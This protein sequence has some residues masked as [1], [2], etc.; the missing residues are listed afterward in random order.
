MKVTYTRPVMDVAGS[1][2]CCGMDLAYHRLEDLVPLSLAPNAITLGGCVQFLLCSLAFFTLLPYGHALI[3][4]LLCASVAV[5]IACDGVDGVHARRIGCACAL[6]DM[7]DNGSDTVFVVFASTL[8]VKVLG[9]SLSSTLGVIAGTVGPWSAVTSTWATLH[10]GEDQGT[11]HHLV[12]I[13][14][15][16]VIG[17]DSLLQAEIACLCIFGVSATNQYI[18]SLIVA[19]IPLGPA[20]LVAL[21]IVVCCP[22]TL[23]SYLVFE[24]SGWQIIMDIRRVKNLCR[25]SYISEL[26]ALSAQLVWRY[27]SLLNEVLD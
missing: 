27:L 11:I 21:V 12:W 8:L 23:E 16:C 19:G 14:L 17:E 24:L 6:G 5:Y 2:L 4:G 25:S 22:R 15:I 13:F 1:W 9:V 20:I 3:C 26:W 10:T 7:L 18:W